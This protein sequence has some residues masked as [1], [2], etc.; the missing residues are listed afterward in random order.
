MADATIEIAIWSNIEA[1]LGITAGSLATL[2]PLLRHWLGSASDTDY[3]R[4]GPSPF[5]AFSGSRSRSRHLPRASR[6]RPF[7]LG[8]LD[9]SV[10]SRLRPDKLAMTV[11]T[12]QTQ[13][14]PEDR[15][16]VLGSGGGSGNSSE[17]RLTENG[18]EHGHG[19]VN[20][21]GRG[22]GHGHGHGQGHG[23]MSS[24]GPR[25]SAERMGIHQIIEVSQ[26]STNVPS[27]SVKEH[28]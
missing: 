28:V 18:N 13:R 25:A 7:P 17:E 14:D 19:K 23:H 24:P 11:T 22:H 3:T 12:V 27:A 15:W 10:Q 2:R 21:H 26:T 8:S 9:E 20:G 4:G 6:E 1:G 5:P 16:P